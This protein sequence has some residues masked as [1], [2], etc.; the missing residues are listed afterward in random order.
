MPHPHAVGA[1]LLALLLV[2]GCG[3][4]STEVKLLVR[5]GAVRAVGSECSGT[6]AHAALH[7][8][9]KFEVRGADG[10][11]VASGSL[12]AGK[13]VAALEEDLKVPRVPT[14]CELTFEVGVPVADSYDLVVDGE[15]IRLQRKDGQLVGM[16]P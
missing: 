1:G 6:G 9:A 15:P 8:S 7:R 4:A 16:V 14:F 11:P 3:T 5:D 10:E 13:A 12:P 2:A